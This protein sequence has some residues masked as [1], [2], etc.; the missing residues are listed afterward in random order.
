MK[1][2][3][4]VKNVRLSKHKS[5]EVQ[6]DLFPKDDV[7]IFKSEFVINQKRDHAGM[8]FFLE[9]YKL[10]Y[11]HIQLYDQRHWDDDRKCWDK[12]RPQQ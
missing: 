11:F 8:S 2:I 6:L 5:I 9:L 12:D 7:V 1:T 4:L 3:M 10:F